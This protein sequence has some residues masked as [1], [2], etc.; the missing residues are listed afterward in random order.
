MF[1]EIER[2]QCPCADSP[3]RKRCRLCHNKTTTQTNYI[4]N[5]RKTKETKKHIL[6]LINHKHSCCVPPKQMWQTKQIQR[7]NE[8]APR[9]PLHNPP[10]SCSRL[11]LEQ[12]NR[13]KFLVGLLPRYPVCRILRPF[14]NRAPP[15]EGIRQTIQN[16]PNQTR[17]V[18]HPRNMNIFISIRKIK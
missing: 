2:T 1:V 5:A 6:E 8:Q 4:E 17:L 13:L 11:W 14:V 7:R 3:I 18:V 10:D 12:Q 16:I 15:P 9:S